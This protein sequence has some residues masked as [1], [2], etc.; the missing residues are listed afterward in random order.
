MPEKFDPY[1]E[2]LGIPPEEQPPNYYQLLGIRLFEDD[3]DVIDGAA[4]RRM[5]HL[6]AFQHGPHAEECHRLL[7]ELSAARICL[8]NPEK[9]AAYDQTLAAK[10]QPAPLP[11]KR[12]STLAERLGLALPPSMRK[13]TKTKPSDSQTMEFSPGQTTARPSDSQTATIE[14]L[15][16]YQLIDKLGE[17]GMGTVYKAVHTKLRRTVAIKVLPKGR[18]SDERAVARFEREMAAV[19]AID[20]PNVVRAHD[21]REIKGTRFLVLEYV[22]GP[23]LTALIKCSGTLAIADACELAR[24]AALGLQA[25][26]EHDLVHRDIKPSNLMVTSQGRVK[27]LDLGLARFQKGEKTT[28]GEVT[29][30]DQM[31]GTPDY[32]A[33][34]QIAETSTVDIRTDIYALGCT[35]YAL[36]AGH[37]PFRGPQFRTTFDKISAHVKEEVPPIIQVRLDLPKPLL[38]VLDR[39]LAKEPDNRF[40][41]PAEVADALGP[42]VEDSDLPA[43]VALAQGKEAPVRPG[44]SHAQTK[45]MG[46]SGSSSTHPDQSGVKRLFQT[47]ADVAKKR[48]VLVAAAV[49]LISIILT[50]IIGLADFGSKPDDEQ[51]APEAPVERPDAGTPEDGSATPSP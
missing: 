27:I 50:L 13:K 45:E 24:Q 16:E 19:G 25:A 32:M 26:S 1:H 15:G 36:L 39:M 33:P 14:Q 6:H 44:Q 20:H 43:L 30:V 41:T 46:A 10:P 7:T 17:G 21:A 38:G 29:A 49:L 48:R 11:E 23:D 5:S 37:P 34:E 35:L 8:L 22:E 51:P 40:A 12:K 9:R 18:L 3:A 47:A 28:D 4:D 42:F 31:V 2:W